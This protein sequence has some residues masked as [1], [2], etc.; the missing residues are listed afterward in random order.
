MRENYI[1]K[2]RSGHWKRFPVHEAEHACFL[3][4][5]KREP[6]VRPLWEHCA[7]R[8]PTAFKSGHLQGLLRLVISASQHNRCCCKSSLWSEQHSRSLSFLASTQLRHMCFHASSC[9]K[10][11]AFIYRANVKEMNIYFVSFQSWNFMRSRGQYSECFCLKSASNW[12]HRDTDQFSLIDRLAC[13]SL[14]RLRFVS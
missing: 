9:L 3:A 13:F 1:M 10:S 11:D 4:S 12:T 8:L 14:Q 5:A 2:N 6:F 7:V